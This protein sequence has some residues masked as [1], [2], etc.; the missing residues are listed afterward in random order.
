MTEYKRNWFSLAGLIGSLFALVGVAVVAQK[1][2]PGQPAQQQPAEAMAFG[3]DARVPIQPQSPFEVFR[4]ARI[5]IADQLPGADL[6]AKINR[7][8]AILGSQRGEVWTFGGDIGTRVTI[9]SN[10][11]LVILGPVTVSAAAT[12]NGAGA[13]VSPVTMQSQTWLRGPGPY[14][15]GVAYLQESS[16]A[17]TWA[18][19]NADGLQTTNAANANA[20]IHVYDLEFR[21]Y[22]GHSDDAG[23]A[24]V[25]H[26]G[27]CVNGSVRRC[28]FTG[29]MHSLVCGAGGGGWNGNRAEN[30]WFT[31]NVFTD[32]PITLWVINGTNCH[33][34]NNT[35][36]RCR[37]CIDLEPNNSHDRLENIHVAGNVL[38]FR[39][40]VGA[41]GS[42][43]TAQKSFINRTGP[44][45]ISGNTLIGAELDTAVSPLIP[46]GISVIGAGRGVI[47]NNVLY[48]FYTAGIALANSAPAASGGGG[49][50]IDSNTLWC[51][52]GNPAGGGGPAIQIRGVN[53][54][55]RNT[56]LY[57]I[58]GISD[59]ARIVETDWTTT[60][61]TNGTAVDAYPTGPF[62]DW[63]NGM[64]VTI[65]MTDYTIAATGTG[66]INGAAGSGMTLSA[67]AGT[68]TGVTLT[69]R[70]RNN[71]YV[72]RNP[73]EVVK[74]H[75]SSVI[76]APAAQP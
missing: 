22:P 49:W 13:V 61:N 18:L 39:G 5:V 57:S 6:G 1:L 60:V 19:V 17:T 65:G 31:E 40:I 75:A 54:E 38:D 28:K 27:N 35:F 30:C 56:R 9:T 67:T 69:F 64:T 42:G 37:T 26:L 33:L 47:A 32:C 7:A 25:V 72:T 4:A 76:Y 8:M 55:V 48:R 20:D 44:F 14:G 63:M 59:D 34:L 36:R 73:S 21:G 58:S 24:A 43:I 53:N 70:T 3:A 10:H 11:G 41:G 46:F 66:A 52:G 71:V 12:L 2:P 29:P 74:L 15:A 50:V 68:Q 16:H 45:Y 62:A 23:G 51:C